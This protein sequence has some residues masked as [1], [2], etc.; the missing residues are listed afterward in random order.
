MAFCAWRFRQLAYLKILFVRPAVY[1]FQLHDL[2][3]ISGFYLAQMGQATI[4]SWP[5]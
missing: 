2:V 5:R 3:A 4:R 1:Q